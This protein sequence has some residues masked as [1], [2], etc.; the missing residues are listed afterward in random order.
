MKSII[1]SLILAASAL[2]AEF[3][4][5]KILPRQDD[6]AFAQTIKDWVVWGSDDDILYRELARGTFNAELS[7]K[8]IPVPKQSARYVRFEGISGNSGDLAAIAEIKLS[9]NGVD[10]PRLG[11]T[12]TADSAASDYPASLAIDGKPETCWHT[13]WLPT[14]ATYPHWI[15]LDTIGPIVGD[16]VDLQWDANPPVPPV[17]G[18]VISYGTNSLAL[19][20]VQAVANVTAAT[21]SGLVPGTWY[22]SLQARSDTGILSQSC[23]QVTATLVAAPLASVPP[24]TPR[25]LRVVPT[26]STTFKPAVK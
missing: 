23:Q 1:L 3:D 19:D 16:S 26:V 2:A 13:A 8:V 22:F 4:T 9:L 25:G 20:R 10:L 17:V 6:P 12:A 11:W 5:L 7:E 18:Y 15:T 24:A 21:I 14:V